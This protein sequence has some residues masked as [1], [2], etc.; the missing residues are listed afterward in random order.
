MH[1]QGRRHVLDRRTGPGRADVAPG[2]DAAPR[3]RGRRQG[4]VRVPGRKGRVRFEGGNALCARS[5]RSE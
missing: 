2:I 1:A 4:P 5:G 3:V